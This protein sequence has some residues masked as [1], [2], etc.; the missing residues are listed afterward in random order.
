MS[1]AIIAP[2]RDPQTWI[3]EFMKCDPSLDVQVYPNISRPDDVT[4][5]VLWLHPYGVL[6]QFP[7]LK[8]MCS[9][10]AGADHM[11]N[12]P[13]LPNIPLTR[14]VSQTIASSMSNFVI[15]AVL[16][17][18]RNMDKYRNDQESKIWD[19]VTFPEISVRIGVMGLGQLGTDVAKKLTY[20]G[21][22]VSGLS[23]SRKSLQG[24]KSYV[25]TEIDRFLDEINVLVC[26]LPM[27]KETRGVL[28]KSLFVKLSNPTYLISVGR[29]YQQV[30][31]DI[32]EAIDM[33]KLTGA[34]L[35]VFE[36]EPLPKNNPIW[37]HPKIKMTPHIASITN[38]AAAV[39]EIFKNYKR[40]M[41]GDEPLHIVN[42]DKG[43]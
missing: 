12:D 13:D 20:L 11:L 3:D 26:L 27:T 38:P 33:G 23:K 1:I 18:H 39:P 14:I 7:N 22:E 25:D 35:D 6:S 24:V 34:F 17:Y 28:N 42:V 41:N 4:C 2:T 16:D 8:L 5:A 15:M 29:G 32:L 37:H 30:E 43:Y 9:M 31:K 36:E 10:G 40:V 19:Q 21:F